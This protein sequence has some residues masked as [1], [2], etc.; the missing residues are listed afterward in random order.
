MILPENGSVV[1]IDDQPEEALPI[2]QVLSKKGIATTYYQGI[3]PALLP[4]EPIQIIRLVFLDLQLIVSVD[5]HQIAKTIAN[6]LN[7]LI[8]QKNGPY[9]LV[10][11]SKNQ[12]KYGEAVKGEIEKYSHL[13]PACIIWFNKRDCLEEEI[14]QDIDS[15]EVEEYVLNRL[16]GRLD[17]EDSRLVR[18]AIADSI[19]DK[20][21]TEFIAKSD[22]LEIIETHI[23]DGLE[24]AGVF[25]LFVIWENLIRNASASTVSAIASTIDST[26]LWEQNMK[27]VLKRMAVARTGQ[28]M[29]PDDDALRASLS[30]FS[31]S[32][33][34]ELESKIREYIFP[35]YINLNSDFIIAGKEND[36]I[37]GIQQFYDENHKSK[38]RLIKNGEEVKGKEKLDFKKIDKLSDG[39]AE[40]DKSF[41]K[42]LSDTFLKVPHQ[43]NS[44]LHLEANPN[45]E[46]IPGNV[47]K[48]EVSDEL[49]KQYLLTY[50]EKLKGDSKNYHFIELEVSPICDYA[51]TKW[52]KSRLI[53]GVIYNE[54]VNPK[55]KD[56]LYVVQPKVLIDDV[57]HRII[58][59]FHLF[60][61]LDKDKV[62]KRE[63]WFRIK[64]EL[65]L[66]IIANLSGHVNRPG[67][68]FM[69]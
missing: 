52:K 2:I 26:N 20:F 27:N 24:A 4:S 59:D 42:S 39:L 17:D 67:I 22:A 64:R 29:V 40:P 16:K 68:S 34:E 62:E 50:F 7:R 9:I 10:V 44:R 30:T 37:I 57:P 54:N 45:Q 14:I 25:H 53:S 21:R 12:A 18:Q 28:N 11:W 47:Y 55:K 49:K 1:I 6:I 3:N 43:I 36:N 56:H 38:V 5:E 33:S 31:S 15:K 23:R 61:S 48:I 66:D 19:N 63:I 41:V 35:E 69:S 58:F 8:S 46:L 32:F 65:L 51:Q 60:K 13:I